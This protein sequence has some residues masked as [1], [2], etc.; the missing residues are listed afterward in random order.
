MDIWKPEDVSRLKAN[1]ALIIDVR[2][3]EE[4]MGGRAI[5]DTKNIPL[6]ELPSRMEELPKDQMIY[7]YCESGMRSQNACL[8]LESKGYKTSNLA[9]GY[10][11]YHAHKG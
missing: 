9:G 8:F 7:V 5:E 10:R 6:G 4:R 11:G 2:E 1:G 3:P